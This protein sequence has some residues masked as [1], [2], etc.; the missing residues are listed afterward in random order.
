[1]KSPYILVALLLLMSS[2]LYG[3]GNYSKGLYGNMLTQ[4]KTIGQ[5]QSSVRQNS[6]VPDDIQGNWQLDKQASLTF[7]KQLPQWNEKLAKLLPKLLTIYA[8]ERNQLS[9]QALIVTTGDN[10]AKISLVLK[11]AN[12]KQYEFIGSIEQQT[13][14]LSISLV[15]NQYLRLQAPELF[16]YQFLLWK[17]TEDS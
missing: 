11:S 14:P 8:K 7:A 15:D 10:D 5:K 2:E 12:N 6:S 17:K 16:G 3:K 4:A 13:F 9:H 1:M